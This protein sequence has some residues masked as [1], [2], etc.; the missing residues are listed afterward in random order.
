MSEASRQNR[1]S[2]TLWIEPE[3][4]PETVNFRSLC[5]IGLLSTLR[6][7]LVPGWRVGSSDR[8]NVSAVAVI[9]APET[10]A[11]FPD[12]T[13]VP[14]NFTSVAPV[15]PEPPIVTD[16]PMGPEVGEKSADG[17][18]RRSHHRDLEDPAVVL[19]RVGAIVDRAVDDPV[20]PL[21]GAVARR[22]YGEPREVPHP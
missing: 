19:I 7:I 12:P 20:V 9:W 17:G 8:T 14:L 18:G 1:R 13:L 10:T 22:S 3:P 11:K 15:K 21:A 5:L 16:V 4:T 6:E 2:F